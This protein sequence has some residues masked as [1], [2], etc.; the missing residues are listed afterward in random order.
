MNT[1]AWVI[2]WASFSDKITGIAEFW[3]I[4][5]SLCIIA[6]LVCMVISKFVSAS[7]DD[8]KDY[9]VP[10]VKSSN[11]FYIVS[12]GWF[13]CCLVA[14][15][16]FGSIYSFVPA[17]DTLYAM[18]ASELVVK[19]AENQQVQT[20]GSDTLKALDE[21]VKRQITPVETKKDK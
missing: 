18:A 10:T 9:N 12:R 4:L 14:G 3:G 15:T 17:K 8:G 13:R 19:T 5:M 11:A 21:W 6:T 20:L 2:Y 16:I 7:Y 1:I